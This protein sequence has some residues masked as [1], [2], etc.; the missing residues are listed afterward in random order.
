MKN[1]YVTL[2]EE[3]DK[4]EE[5]LTEEWKERKDTEIKQVCIKKLLF[6]SKSECMHHVYLVIR[7]D[8]SNPRQ[9]Q[10]VTLHSLL[11]KLCHFYWVSNF[12][13]SCKNN[14]RSSGYNLFIRIDLFLCE[15][16]FNI[17]IMMLKKCIICY[18]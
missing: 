17:N 13:T 9:H 14:G 12:F 4:L 6:Y 2:C 10:N 1:V 8:F 11:T 5:R 16:K 15:H 18:C 3:K 7:Q